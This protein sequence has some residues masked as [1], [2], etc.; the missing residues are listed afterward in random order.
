[1]LALLRPF[2]CQMK[3]HT[4]QLVQIFEA[5]YWNVINKMLQAPVIIWL[6]VPEVP[7]SEGYLVS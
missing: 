4:P 1:M 2:K 3:S 7:A 6:Q 5:I